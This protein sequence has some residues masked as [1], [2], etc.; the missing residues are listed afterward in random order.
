MPDSPTSEP[1]S[2]FVCDCEE[3]MRSACAGEP[4]YKEHDDNRYCV[5]HFPGSEKSRDF[6]KAFLRKLTDQDFD[7][8]GVWFPEDLSFKGFEFAGH[9]NFRF[10]YFHS[11]VSFESAR[12]TAEADFR[13]TTF[14]DDADFGDVTFRGYAYFTR[15]VFHA[16]AN[17][18]NASFDT[19]A[20]FTKAKFEAPAIFI[21]ASF[22]E[23]VYFQQTTFEAETYFTY[24]SFQSYALF[25]GNF[26]S[27]VIGDETS[28][29]F[30]FARIE[31][32]E[33]ISFHTLKR[34]PQA[35][36]LL[37]IVCRHL[38]VNAE[39]NHRY[40]EASK[41]RYMAMNA[42]RNESW[43]GFAPWKLGWWYWL[44]SGYGERVLK[45][46]LILIVIWLAFGLP[47]TRV[48]F[49]RGSRAPG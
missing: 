33:R 44:A 9:T 30:Q 21:S 34:I 7:F 29:D 2:A 23:R 32:P 14:E 15:A 40:E 18:I 16:R 48:G 22:S 11:K 27:Q 24:T 5:L 35:H 12:F 47:Y 6:N 46:F 45:A 10:A 38:A 37:A 36:R 4:F 31:R 42:R 28:L 41:F 19:R 43:R 13:D 1:E 3:R 25:S 20:F 17:F 26:Q 8:L 39:E 49:A